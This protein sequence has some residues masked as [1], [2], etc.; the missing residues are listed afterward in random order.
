MTIGGEVGERIGELIEFRALSWTV[1]GLFVG[2]VGANAQIVQ[3]DSGFPLLTLI[4]LQ[5]K[6]ARGYRGRSHAIP[7]L[8]HATRTFCS[9][10]QHT[11][12]KIFD[13]KPHLGD[14]A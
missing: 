11:H 7:Q 4:L 5:R 1:T 14:A 12:Y 8:P 13:W 9:F 3:K 2:G 6:L 10:C